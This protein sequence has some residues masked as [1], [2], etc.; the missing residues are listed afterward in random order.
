MGIASPAE[1]VELY[2]SGQP[3]HPYSSIGNNAWVFADNGLS[4]LA[5][6]T[7]DP[8]LS[9][10]CLRFVEVLTAATGGGDIGGRQPY[11]LDPNDLRAAGHALI[12]AG[13]HLLGTA[14]MSARAARRGQA[15]SAAQV[16]W[17][18]DFEAVIETM[19]RL[20][21]CPNEASLVRLLGKSPSYISQNR[22]RG[23]MPKQMLRKFEQLIA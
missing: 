15:T 5:N 8:D 13:H 1:L 18:D 10:L 7:S 2:T 20:S 17:P 12:S 11:E 19:L 6:S 16:T 9:M 23:V 3:P 14:N 21:G 4:A 22:A